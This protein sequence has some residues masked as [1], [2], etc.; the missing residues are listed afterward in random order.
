MRRTEWA[1]ARRRKYTKS[2]TITPSFSHAYIIESRSPA[3]ELNL[4]KPWDVQLCPCPCPCCQS[5]HFLCC[6]EQTRIVVL[7]VPPLKFLRQIGFGRVLQAHIG[8]LQVPCMNQ[9]R[10]TICVCKQLHAITISV[11][12]TSERER[13]M[14][15]PSL[16]ETT[17]N[18]EEVN[19]FRN[20]RPI[21]SA[22]KKKK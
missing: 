21:F 9:S 5:S 22:A 18:C 15:T 17:M 19:R 3:T 4:S 1:L 16:R 13:K 14:R 7:F 12:R 11:T 2:T 8:Q 20:R 6:I 10:R